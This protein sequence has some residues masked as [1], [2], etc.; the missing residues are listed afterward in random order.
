MV[1]EDVEVEAELLWS[2]LTESDGCAAGKAFTPC[3]SDS[4][5]LPLPLSFSL[6]IA[7]EVELENLCS[8]LGKVLD[9]VGARG[10][11]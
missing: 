5:V 7:L 1:Q 9:F 4:L 6:L 8:R 3:F 10:P 11:L 2:R